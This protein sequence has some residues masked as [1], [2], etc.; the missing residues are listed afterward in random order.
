MVEIDHDIVKAVPLQEQEI[1]HDERS[2]CDGE[3]RLGDRIRQRSE[4]RAQARRQDHGFHVASAEDRVLSAECAEP[5][6]VL[7]ALSPVLLLQFWHIGTHE[8]P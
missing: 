8:F 3:Q 2:A 1:P 7:S 5:P 4:A 6:S